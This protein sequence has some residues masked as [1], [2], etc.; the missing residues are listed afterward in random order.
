M[1]RKFRPTEL[2]QATPGGTTVTEGDELADVAKRL[3][4][5]SSALVDRILSSDSRTFNRSNQQPG[6]Q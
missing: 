6:A 4:A 2:A 1:D 5:E 3:L